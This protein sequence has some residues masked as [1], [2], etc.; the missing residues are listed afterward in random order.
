[1]TLVERQDA[2]KKRVCW[3]NLA[4]GV[5]PAALYLLA[6]LIGSAL[7]A[8]AYYATRPKLC[9]APL[10]TPPWFLSWDIYITFLFT[11]FL[12]LILTILIPNQRGG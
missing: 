3:K 1:M 4:A 6:F 11:I 12:I 2:C 9:T 5:I 8:S 10:I 7:G